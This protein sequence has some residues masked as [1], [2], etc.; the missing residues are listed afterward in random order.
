MLEISVLCSDRALFIPAVARHRRQVGATK[1]E[2]RSLH[3]AARLQSASEALSLSS[4]NPAANNRRADILEA[5]CKVKCCVGLP[6]SAGTTTVSEY[7]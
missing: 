6:S 1:V 2:L 4:A 5:L 3:S 7:V